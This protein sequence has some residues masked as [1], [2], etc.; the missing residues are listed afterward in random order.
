MFGAE[1]NSDEACAH[2]ARQRGAFQQAQGPRGPSGLRLIQATPNL[3]L[4]SRLHALREAR[5]KPAAMLYF[6]EI[7][8]AHCAFAKRLCQYVGRGD[9]VLDGQIDTDTSDR[10][11][12]MGCIADAQQAGP[13]PLPQ[14]IGPDG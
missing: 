14:T 9:S 3:L 2:P 12:G 7:V 10:R 8:A 13:M 4:D 11:H 6:L 1:A 5:G